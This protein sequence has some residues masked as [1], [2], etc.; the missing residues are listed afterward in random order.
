MNELNQIHCRAQADLGTPRGKRLEELLAGSHG[1]WAC[2]RTGRSVWVRLGVGTEARE[3]GAVEHQAE[4]EEALGSC[5][6][7]G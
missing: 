5:V 2:W 4:V 7:N 3:D 6:S 1:A